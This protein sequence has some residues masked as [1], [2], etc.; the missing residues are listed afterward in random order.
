MKINVGSKNKVKI[1]AVKHA[2]SL[3]PNLFPAA[4]IFG[5]EIEID[6]Y[7]HPKNFDETMRGAVERAKKA[8]E[9]CDYSFGLE[10]GLLEV[11][12]SKSG[13]ME[14]SACAIYDGK[15][16]YVGLGPAF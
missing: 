9:N 14:V 12:H 13:F 4:E 10:G 7:G 2:V 1:D 8:F 11:P 3:Y 5:K 15:N 6:L 16:V